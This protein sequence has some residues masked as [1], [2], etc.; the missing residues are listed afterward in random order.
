MKQIFT[1]YEDWS[2]EQVHC[3]QQDSVL[4][5]DWK[6]HNTSLGRDTRKTPIG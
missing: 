3:Y 2:A 4:I 5:A 6:Y 1:W